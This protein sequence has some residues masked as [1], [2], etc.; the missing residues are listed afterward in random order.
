MVVPGVVV[1]VGVETGVQVAVAGADVAVAGG[2]A[3]VA[4]NASAVTVALTCD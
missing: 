3:A 4:V 1:Q 2:V